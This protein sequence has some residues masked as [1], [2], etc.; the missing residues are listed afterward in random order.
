LVSGPVALTAPQ[1]V[2]VIPITTARDMFDA[3]SE[4]Q[5]WADYVIMSAAVADYRPQDVA[6]EKIKKSDGDLELRL[7]RNPDILAH[8][9]QHKKPGQLICGFAMETSDL[10]KNAKEKLKKKNCDLLIG[11]HL[12]TPGAGFQG[13]TNV[14]SVLT[15]NS[16]V[17]WPKQSKSELGYNILEALLQLEK[18]SE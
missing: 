10:D 16:L 2:E 12:F 4:N 5:D 6:E 14:V 9:G 8:L 18:E 17:H 3:M 7:V 11:N 15:V 1:G 13:D